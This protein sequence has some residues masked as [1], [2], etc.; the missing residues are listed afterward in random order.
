MPLALRDEFRYTYE[1]YRNWKGDWELI[2]GIAVAMAPAWGVK[3][4]KLASEF[5]YTI[6]EQ[7][8]DCE[9]CDVVGEID[10][11]VN[12]NTVLRPDIALICN[13][14]GKNY[15]TK[16]PE[17]VVEIVSPSTSRR[18]EIYKF[19][20]YEEEKVKYYILV[21]PEDLS[22]KLY[23]LD[24]KN[25]DKIG[26]FTNKTYKFENTTCDIEIDFAKI[27]RRFRK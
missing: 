10:Y 18:D 14:D 21:Y 16:A 19:H 1:D 26:D 6:R 22:A 2:D 20:I 27:F 3:H 9:I 15:I 11:K 4:K 23:K 17:I 8:D 12:D 13:D 25:Y 24:G 5:I 7:L